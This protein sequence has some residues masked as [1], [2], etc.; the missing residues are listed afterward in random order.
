MEPISHLVK[1][2]LPNYLSNLP[3]PDSIGGWFRLGFKDWLRLVP[4]GAAVGGLGYMSYRA[5][6][7]KGRCQGKVNPNIKKDVAKVVDSVDIEDITEKAAFCRCWRSK[8]FPYCDGSH[9]PMNK[10]LG[11]NVGPIIVKHK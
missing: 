6:C 1:V 4:F 2:S 7:P 8:K 9:G 3:L 10:E 5:F 11:D